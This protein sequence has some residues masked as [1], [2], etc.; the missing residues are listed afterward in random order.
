M[1]GRHRLEVD[2]EVAETLAEGRG[3]VALESTIIAQGLPR[4]ENLR[5]ARD[6]E[7]TVRRSGATPATIAVL[8]GVVHVGLTG[9]QLASIA[10]RED[11]AK[12][13]TRDL[14]PAVAAG[15]TGATTVAATARIARLVGIEVMA[16]GGLGG[17]HREA[18]RTWDESPDLVALG[19]TGIT[20]VSAGVKSIL[21]VA[22]T[23]ERLESLNVTVLGYR[24]N[25]FPA[26]YL[27]D[28][29]LTVDWRIES[30]EEVAAILR[31]RV[32]LGLHHSAVLVANPVA[33]DV[34]LDV[35]THD[36]ALRSGLEE[37]ERQG[38]RGK[39]VTPF[40]LEWLH[41]ET[42]G[43]S[44]RANEEIIKNNAELAGHIAT[45]LSS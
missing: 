17:V 22:A 11:V 16:T 5:V 28:S 35:E 2:P 45:S 33:K 1:T 4:P 29:G 12:L 7:A 40:L 6:V 23:L 36:W 15:V 31:A 41:R 27:V 44:L 9:P 14:A 42:A 32:A 25:R 13:S 34:A 21:D 18:R 3:V 8:D 43:G 19:T 37:A 26:F 38:V 30:A 10:E 20:V 39:A 24:T